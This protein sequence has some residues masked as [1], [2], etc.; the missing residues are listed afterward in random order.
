LTDTQQ[1]LDWFRQMIEIRL[2]E[3]KVQELLQQG[4]VEGTT[5]L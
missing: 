1:H 5:H 3:D 2:S 4:L